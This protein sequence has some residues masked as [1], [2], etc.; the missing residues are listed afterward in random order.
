MG[1]PASGEPGVK[2][3]GTRTKALRRLRVA[4]LGAGSAALLAAMTV[5]AESGRARDLLWSAA[6]VCLGVSL[7]ANHLLR[8][9][10]E[11]EARAATGTG[12]EPPD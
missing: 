2:G 8:R 11:A 9:A 1:T 10:E 3:R 7:V 12:D 5:L 4:A 6:V